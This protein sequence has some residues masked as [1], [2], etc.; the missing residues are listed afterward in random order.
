MDLMQ[1]IEAIQ[2]PDIEIT[3]LETIFVGV[4]I[5]LLSMVVV[6]IVLFMIAIM[7]TIINR[8]EKQPALA[9]AAAPVATAPQ[10]IVPAKAVASTEIKKPQIEKRIRRGGNPDMIKTYYV[11]VNGNTYDVEVEE[12]PQT[13]EARATPA[14]RPVAAPVA[15]VPTPAPQ[16]VPVSTGGTNI[17]S[18]MP[19]MI[20]AVRVKVGDAVK[21]GQV[22]VVLEAMKMENEIIAT[23]D[24][25]VASVQVSEGASINA[26][27]VLVVI[28]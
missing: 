4:I 21:N 24:G 8:P 1:L 20:R 10:P 9:A 25:T 22:L 5:S 11:T 23:C 16:P 18:P 7:I 3:M 6:V 19:G 27:D 2:R 17:E 26:Q 28:S 14:P 13:G 15:A 12:V